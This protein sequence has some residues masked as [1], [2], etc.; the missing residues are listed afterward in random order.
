VF[1]KL[2]QD[3]IHHIHWVLAPENHPE[4]ISNPCNKLFSILEISRFIVRLSTPMQDINFAFD[5]TKTDSQ[6]RERLQKLKWL[7]PLAEEAKQKRKQGK[8]RVSYAQVPNSEK[9]DIL[10]SRSILFSCRC[11]SI[12]ND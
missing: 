9:K 12:S 2:L 3:A 6:E 8:K 10:R 11:G 7:P 4:K 5:P 1:E